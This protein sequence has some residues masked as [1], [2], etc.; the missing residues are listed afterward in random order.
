MANGREVAKRDWFWRP[1]RGS[2]LGA[3]KK[4]SEG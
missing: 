4:N 3:H 1:G 2:N